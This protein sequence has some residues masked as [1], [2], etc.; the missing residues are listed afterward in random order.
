MSDLD[1]T[2]HRVPQDGRFKLIISR[3]RAVDFRVSVC[4]TVFGEKVVLRIL[5]SS[6][7]TQGVDQL[8]WQFYKKDHLMNSLQRSQGLILVT[9]PTGSGK[10]VTLYS[11]TQLFKF[12]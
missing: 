12:Q 10:T 9:G 8:V 1:I 6:H 2:E 7:I 4:P 5:D 3:K 11:A